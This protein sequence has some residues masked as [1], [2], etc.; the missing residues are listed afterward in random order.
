MQRKIYWGDRGRK[1]QN[2]CIVNT[3]GTYEA[4]INKAG[5]SVRECMVMKKFGI[6]SLLNISS[7]N[8][9]LISSYIKN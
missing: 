7:K 9:Y 3:F 2:A 5:T 4:K 1:N 8:T 6:F